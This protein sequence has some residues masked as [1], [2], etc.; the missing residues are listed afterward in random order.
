MIK[1]DSLIWIALL[2]LNLVAVG[3]RS[4]MQVQSDLPK[5]EQES[6]TP[7]S[8]SSTSSTSLTSAPSQVQTQSQASVPQQSASEDNMQSETAVAQGCLDAW[9]VAV[10]QKDEAKSME[11]LQK[12]AKENPNIS[13]IPFMM[14]QVKDFF[15]KPKEALVY[16]RKAYS[17]NKYSSI[18]ILRLAASLR[19]N[20]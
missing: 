10:M 18:Q 12:L 20:G 7:A 17:I 1:S 11:M 16:F 2:A 8:T 15:K 6:G 5:V 9:K 3:C 4:Q 19:K 13:T 14:G